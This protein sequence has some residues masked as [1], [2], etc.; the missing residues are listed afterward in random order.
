[1]YRQGLKPAVQ[2]ELI[3]SRATINTLKELVSEAIQVDNKLYKLALEERLFNQGT[4]TSKR[5]NNRP[6]QG[7][8]RSEPNQGRPRNY[9]PRV[10]G[11]YTTIGYE[12]MHLNNINKGPGKP[13]FHNR[14]KKKITYYNYNKEGHIARDYQSKNKVI[15]QLNILTYSQDKGIEEEE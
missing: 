4:R 7:P 8:Q 11:A 5:T 15:Q 6:R 3:R 10:P 14:N 13:K 12:P 9:P 2:R 1:M